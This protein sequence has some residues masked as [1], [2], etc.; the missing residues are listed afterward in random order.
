MVREQATLSHVLSNYSR[1]QQCTLKQ[2]FVIT[3]GRKSF[4]YSVFQ[5]SHR[6][7]G[8]T[9]QVFKSVVEMTAVLI[10]TVFHQ[11]QNGLYILFKYNMYCFQLAFYN[12][13]DFSDIRTRILPGQVCLALG[14]CSYGPSLFQLHSGLCRGQTSQSLHNMLCV[15]L[16][17]RPAASGQVQ[18]DGLA[19][20]SPQSP[21]RQ[22]IVHPNTL[23]TFVVEANFT[24][25]TALFVM[26]V[27]AVKENH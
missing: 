27:S 7:A 2:C 23:C 17:H 12:G 15:L 10:C 26:S 18:R 3:L 16:Q 1:C 25:L 5:V 13:K 20:S 6:S 4:W 11:H 8:L 19:L 24:A 21:H 22:H 9:F 14:H